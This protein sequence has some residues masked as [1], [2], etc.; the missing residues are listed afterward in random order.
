AA[1][2][3]SSESHR[4]TDAMELGGLR[5]VQALGDGDL[6]P[7]CSA[8]LCHIYG[9]VMDVAWCGAVPVWLVREGVVVRRT[10]PHLLVEEMLRTGQI[11]EEQARTLSLR[12][13]I[14]RSIGHHPPQGSS[15]AHPDTERWTVLHGDRVLLGHQQTL[16]H[17]TPELIARAASLPLDAM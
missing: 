6:L 7:G 5:M 8:A 3:V 9:D 14:I 1:A 16:E 10:R 4:L 17:A 2:A 11:S 15:P 12:N 13:V